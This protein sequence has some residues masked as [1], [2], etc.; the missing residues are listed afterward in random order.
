MSVSQGLAVVALSP[1][2]ESKIM[3]VTGLIQVMVGRLGWL[4]HGH[5][6]MMYPPSTVDREGARLRA[7]HRAGRFTRQLGWRVRPSTL[8]FVLTGSPLWLHFAWRLLALTWVFTGSPALAALGLWFKV[9]PPALTF[10]LIFMIDSPCSVD[11]SWEACRPVVAA[12]NSV[13]K[14]CRAIRSII[15]FVGDEESSPR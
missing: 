11:A 14:A 4:Y 2:V 3:V 5:V 1:Q 15:G 13:L 6:G 12:S 9:I 7:G 8:T 10:V